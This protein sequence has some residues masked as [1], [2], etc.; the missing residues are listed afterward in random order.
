M[1]RLIPKDK[2][3]VYRGVIEAEPAIFVFLLLYSLHFEIYLERPTLQSK[4]LVHVHQ[5]FS[6]FEFRKAY[7]AIRKNRPLNTLPFFWFSAIKIFEMSH[8]AILFNK[9]LYDLLR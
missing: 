9:L 6:V 8:C 7:K 4:F 1:R 2:I 5:R 3:S